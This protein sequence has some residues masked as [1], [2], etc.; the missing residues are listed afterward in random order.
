MMTVALAC[1]VL[2]WP[3]V[4]TRAD[5]PRAAKESASLEAA[6]FFE[7]RVRPILAERCVK[8]HGPRKQSSGLR[9][10]SR[11]SILGGGN[12]GPAVVPSKPDESLLIQAV[13]RTHDELK[14]PPDGRLSEPEVAILARWVALGVPWPDD[15]KT[16]VSR[17]AAAPGGVPAHW[18]FRP[19]GPASPAPA[20]RGSGAAS[21]IDAFVRARL[22][23]AGIAPSPRAD[24]RTLIRRATFDLCGIPPTAEEI[25][26]FEADSSPGAFARVVDRLLASPRYGERWGR[27]W[28]DVARYADTKGYV[29]TQERRY[30][31]AF[32]YRDY[33]IGA[34][35]ADLGYDRFILEQLA[36][37]QLPRNG[38]NRSL[39]AMGFLTVGRRFLLDQNEIIDDRIDVVCRGLLGL[40]VTCARCHDH[41]FDPIPTDDYY[42]LYGVFASSVE[43]AELPALETPVGRTS[44]GAAGYK[45]KLEAARAQRDRY[46]AARQAEVQKDLGERFSLY[47]QAAYDLGLDPRNRCLEERALAAK[48]NSRRLRGVILVWKRY[49]E[50]AGAQ[51]PVVGPLQAFSALP[52]VDF[53]AKAA[54]IQAPWTHATEP[55]ARPAHPL[56]ARLVLVTPPRG[57]NEVVARYATL[58]AQLEERT[59]AA[60]GKPHG[61]TMTPLADPEWESLRQV[62]FG[63]TGPFGPSMD[64]RRLFLDQRQRGQLEALN[65]AIDRLNATDPA[66]PTRAMVLYDVA[67]AVE[68]HVFVRGNPGRPGKAVPRRFLAVLAGSSRAPFQKGSGRLELAQAIADARNPLTAR[69]LV[70]RVWHWHFGKGLVTTP[71]D[72][73]LRSDPPTHPELLDD[74][75]RTFLADGWSVKALQRRIMLSSTYQQA[76]APRLE[77]MAH[78]PENRLLWRFAPQRLDFEAMRDSILAVSGALDPVL[79]G[80]PVPINDRPFSMRRTVYGFIDRQNLDSLYRT[81]DFAVPDATSPRRFVTTVPQQA[82]FLMN[83]PLLHEQ[84]RRL[85]ATVDGDGETGKLDLAQAGWVRRLYLRVLGR[86]PTPG[87]LA[88]ALEFLRGES[89]SKLAGLDG[90]RLPVS[91]AGGGPAQERPLSPRAELAQVL[92]LTNEFMFIE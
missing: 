46:L 61:D 74:L 63:S 88:L 9:L 51:D 42:S 60:A 90:W 55:K 65:G 44:S 71:S 75:A 43:P 19:M 23:A 24:R 59:R 10:D 58:F 53:A 64:L 41:K 81:F 84:V 67:R 86:S 73:G 68:P 70:N 31:Y 5:E 20:S 12:S 18:A 34:F 30:P 21:S 52:H 39:A 40:T 76:S 22:D 48:L 78:D 62:L 79:G 45:Q 92:M 2:S 49:V 56:V 80:R 37:D 8:C 91:A 6:E 72:F 7:A 36:A 54:V 85:V 13:A 69:V 47:L 25:E 50:S 29:F 82:L 4:A 87:E 83:S 32:T 26:A 66:A 16:A 27:H 89:R 57:M 17:T 35:N 1:L 15:R 28:L 3:T 11:Q 33:V 77:V 14:M 38:D